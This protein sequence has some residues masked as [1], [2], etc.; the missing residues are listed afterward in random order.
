[1][2]CYLQYYC[3]MCVLLSAAVL[4]HINVLRPLQLAHFNFFLILYLCVGEVRQYFP[5]VDL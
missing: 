3:I 1:M 2:I 5:G 4:V